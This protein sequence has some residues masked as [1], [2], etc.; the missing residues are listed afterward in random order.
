MVL[1]FGSM[2][3]QWQSAGIFTYVLPFLIIFAIV[4]SVLSYTNVFRGN[5]GVAV[6][7]SLAV[8]LL[9]LQ[10]EIVPV[11]FSEIAPKMGVGLFLL[12]ILVIIGGF[13][14]DPNDEKGWLRWVLLGATVIVM[15]VVVGSSLGSIGFGGFGGFGFLRGR[16]WGNILTIAIIVGLIA[17]IIGKTNKG[18]QR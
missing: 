10:F 18:P 1:D 14:F 16:D 13:F 15:I 2:F 8:S 3:A 12:L 4:F 5:K 6:V 11:F 7:V 17:L 9:A